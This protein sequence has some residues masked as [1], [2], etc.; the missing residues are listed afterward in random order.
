MDDLTRIEAPAE[1]PP[2]EPHI[3]I[4][5]RYQISVSYRH[6][7][8]RYTSGAVTLERY[9]ELLDAALLKWQLEKGLERPE[10]NPTREQIPA[11]KQK[12]E[13]RLALRRG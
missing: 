7:N 4:D 8:G 2:W 5:Q 6:D 13:A 1:A 11:L 3:G 10:H 9:V 12:E